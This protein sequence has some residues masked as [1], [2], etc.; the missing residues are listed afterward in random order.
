MRPDPTSAVPPPS[1]PPG[2]SVAKPA[3]VYALLFGAVAAYAPYIA[4]Y[5]RS[6]GLELETVGVLIALQAAVGLVAA[7]AWGALADR[8]GDVRGP[9]LVSSLLAA[10]AA[11]LLGAVSGPLL[12]AGSIALVATGMAG[13]TPMVDSRAVRLVGRRERFGRARAWGSAAFIV[14]A[15]ATGAAIGSF[16]PE[17][18]FVLYAPLIAATGVAAFALLRLRD[19]EWGQRS[20]DPPSPGGRRP[21]TRSTFSLGTI[22]GAIRQPIIGR[23]FIG[24]VIVWT[25]FAT[26]QTFV[27]LRVIQLGGDATTVGAT[28]SLGALV[29]IPLMFA[30]PNLARRFGAERLLIIGAMAFAVRAAG[31]ALAPTPWLVVAVSPAGGVGFAFFYVGTVTWVAGA[32]PRS[33]QATAQGIFTGTAVSIGAIGGAILGGLIGGALS[34]PVLFLVAAVGHAVG[35]IVVWQAVGRRP[36]GGGQLG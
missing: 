19:E 24:S 23:F 33:I 3:I 20:N 8:R 18:M 34:L 32:L 14:A 15:F 7:P 36:A 13:I 17:G 16:G 12:L 31:V 29:E 9:I 1:L 26:L 6:R 5:L 22:S 21:T 4:V 35:A 2:S 30:F 25:A 28:W 27:S 11:V 10:G